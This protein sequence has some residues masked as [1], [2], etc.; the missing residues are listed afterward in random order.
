MQLNG[1]HWE[2]VTGATQIDQVCVGG[3]VKD[4]EFFYVM[5]N[6]AHM[7]GDGVLGLTPDFKKSHN[8]F[9]QYLLN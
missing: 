5:S 4:Y 7:I 6:G 9:G 3:C 1:S 8:S 2:I